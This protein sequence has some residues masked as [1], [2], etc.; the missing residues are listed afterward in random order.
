LQAHTGRVSP[1]SQYFYNFGSDSGTFFR[2]NLDT[3]EMDKS[4]YTGGTPKQASQP[5]ELGSDY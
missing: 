1:D 2:I 5:S 4:V 3:L